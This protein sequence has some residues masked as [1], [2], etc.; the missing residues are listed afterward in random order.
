MPLSICL[1]AKDTHVPMTRLP[2]DP[3]TTEQFL[4]PNHVY[5]F[6]MKY[7][8]ETKKYIVWRKINKT[9]TAEDWEK[10]RYVGLLQTSGDSIFQY[11]EQIDLLLDNKKFDGRVYVLASAVELIF[12]TPKTDIMTVAN[13]TELLDEKFSMATTTMQNNVQHIY[14]TP[15]NYNLVDGKY[16]GSFSSIA[17]KV[18]H[19]NLML[20]HVAAKV[21]INWTVP[22][23]KRIKEDPAKAV[24]LTYMQAV[25]LFAGDAYCFK[26]MANVVEVD[27]LPT[28]VFSRQIVSPGDVGLWWEGRDYF[29][30]IPYTTSTHPGYFPLQMVMKT[31]GSTGTGYRPT[32]Y[33]QMNDTTFVP[34]LRA[35]FTINNPLT[36]GTTDTITVPKN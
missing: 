7:D 13:E 25:N 20:Y 5:I 18:P 35:D 26:P 23:D 34:W 1:P 21:D 4:L 32:L 14:S 19:L 27:P 3:G 29:Y 30:T 36:D 33:M 6:V 22:T 9:L 12:T 16:Y 31:N 17:Q 24:R 8:T 11:T 2:G 28:T 15:Y 10:K